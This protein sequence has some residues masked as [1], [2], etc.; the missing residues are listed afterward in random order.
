MYELHSL[1]PHKLEA[2]D[3]IEELKPRKHFLSKYVS[4]INAKIIDSSGQRSPFKTQYRNTLE[5]SLNI[6]CATATNS[7]GYLEAV[8]LPGVGRYHRPAA[9]EVRRGR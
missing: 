8:L 2:T 6:S 7:Q 5:G 3:E 1:H 9:E 4:A